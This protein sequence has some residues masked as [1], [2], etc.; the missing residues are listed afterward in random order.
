V[1]GV[2]LVPCILAGLGAA[3]LIRF[4]PR[5]VSSIIAG[6]LV[7]LVYIL[8]LRPSSLG[9]ERSVTYEALQL[10]PRDEVI[11]F[12]RAL[13][14]L[15]N[16]G[17]LIEIPIDTSDV[18]YNFVDSGVQVLMTA[19]HHRRTSAC[20]ISYHPPTFAEVQLLSRT[21]PAPDATQALAKLGFTTVVLRHEKVNVRRQSL[22]DAFA[23]AARAPTSH[24]RYLHGDESM[25][26]YA[27]GS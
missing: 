14:E 8:T 26:A 27:I 9:L 17:P 10:K 11:A 24:L 16:V 19:Y 20:A 5:R 18:R 22:R 3:A 12:F 23:R 7:G 21:L 6:A 2:Y 4:V 15:G 13:D 1:T 25:T